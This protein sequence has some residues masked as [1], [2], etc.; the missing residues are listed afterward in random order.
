MSSH[1][2]YIKNIKEKKMK[3]KHERSHQTF[4]KITYHT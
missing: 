2:D 1:K 3:E 4:D